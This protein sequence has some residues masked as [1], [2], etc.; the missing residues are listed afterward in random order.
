M[1]LEE[2]L[3]YSA[4]EKIRDST[5]SSIV[6]SP[7]T[8]CV[9]SLNDGVLEVLEFPRRASFIG[10]QS[11]IKSKHK[12]TGSHRSAGSRISTPQPLNDG[13]DGGLIK[14]LSLPLSHIYSVFYPA[15][16]TEFELVFNYPNQFED[17][18]DEPT[19]DFKQISVTLKAATAEQAEKWVKY[20]LCAVQN[21]ATYIDKLTDTLRKKEDLEGTWTVE[22]LLRLSVDMW[23]LVKGVRHVEVA[24]AQER[25]AE[26]LQEQGDKENEGL[27]W[28]DKAKEIKEV[29]SKEDITPST[30][31]EEILKDL[32][33]N[34]LE[35]AL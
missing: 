15:R 17:E 2:V 4:D 3:Y 14:T 22:D 16:T 19:K 1:S 10:R 26:Y 32:D 29:L 7:N 18:I 27:F 11:V 31:M 8:N 9:V 33:E 35:F 6:N 20:V 24:K 25:L 12:S 5:R 23:T 28:T 30:V 13:P 21:Q 34:G